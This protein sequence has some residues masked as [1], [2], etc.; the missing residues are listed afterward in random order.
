MDDTPPITPLPQS[1]PPLGVIWNWLRLVYN[2]MAGEADVNISSTA[3]FTP[4]QIK[5]YYPVDTSG[6]SVT[7]SL[8][9]AISLLGKKYFF[10]KT[11]A[12]NSLILTAATGDTIDGSSSKTYTAIYDGA[13]LVSDGVSRWAVCTRTGSTPIVG[14]GGLT[15]QVQFND[16]GVLAGNAG[17]TYNKVTNILTVGLSDKGGQVYNVKAY[18]V[19]G[20]GSTDDTTAINTLATTVFTAGGG[21]LF[22]P[23]GTYVLT[24]SIF[25]QD[26]VSM[27]GSGRQVT[28]FYLKS[29]S[30]LTSAHGIIEPNQIGGIPGRGYYSKNNYFAHFSINGNIAG[31]GVHIYEGFAGYQCKNL[32]IEDVE[33]YNNGETGFAGQ[34]TNVG[35]DQY[36][37]LS[38]VNC[39]AHDNT[40][41]GFQGGGVMWLDCFSYSN[42][43]AGFNSVGNFVSGI[44]S[45]ICTQILNCR[46]ENNTNGGIGSSLQTGPDIATLISNC[47]TNWNLSNGIYIDM[48]Y[49][50]IIGCNVQ[51]N[52]GDGIEL[53]AD[54]SVISNCHVMNNGQSEVGAQNYESG[55][56]VTGAR[57]YCTISNNICTDNQGAPTQDYG[58]A[59]PSAGGG[60]NNNLTDNILTGNIITPIYLVASATDWNITNNV[61]YNPQSVL[62]TTVA[63]KLGIGYAPGSFTLDVNGSINMANGGSQALSVAGGYNLISGNG[64][65]GTTIIYTGNGNIGISL[66]GSGTPGTLTNIYANNTHKF[67]TFNDGADIAIIDNTKGLSLVNAG[68]GIQIKEGS[69]ARMGVVT[70]VLGVKVVSNTS[71]TANSRIFL[72][73]ESLGT[74]TVPTVV[75]VT[76]RTPGTSFTITSANL[77]DTSV[78][79]WFIMEPA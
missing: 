49:T 13:V 14:A 76:A 67:A 45:H 9:P 15:T 56:K 68:L 70:L 36:S 74:V 8:P 51:Y 55:I 69:N 44:S 17:F 37:S 46:A 79:S 1:S 26:N 7:V 41:D 18:G 38:Y 6:G 30:S 40:S 23:P 77:T 22:F 57:N 31:N 47:N 19:L 34:V 61:G 42:L 60:S 24:A 64:G 5:Y 29:G 75:A 54:F 43:G 3:S 66:D 27:I 78:I 63:N 2:W 4:S 21:T 73:V 62:N 39:I 20:D 52:N 25:I 16:T 33:S 65:N 58:I 10:S 35:T 59:F 32:V 11:S 53:G 28:I 50:T 72:S 71:V 12:A 48:K